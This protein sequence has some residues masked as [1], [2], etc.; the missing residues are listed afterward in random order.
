MNTNQEKSPTNRKADIHIHF[1]EFE[2]PPMQDVMLIGRR[3][4]IGPEAVR[5]MVDALTPG[6]YKVI[7]INHD[8][9][10]AIAVRTMLFNWISKDKLINTIMEEANQIANEKSLVKAKLDITVSVFKE[11]EL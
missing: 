6:Q 8:Y 5:R 3:A 7:K 1:S 10:E 9:I 2:L 11:I 4:P